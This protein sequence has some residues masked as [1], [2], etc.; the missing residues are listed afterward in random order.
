M[1]RVA[2]YCLGNKLVSLAKDRKTAETMECQGLE[3]IFPEGETLYFWPEQVKLSI[4]ETVREKLDIC[5]DYDVFQINSAGIFYRCYDS[6][7]ADNALMITAHCNS[8][9]IMCP[10]TDTQRKS[11]NTPDLREFLNIIRHIPS[12]CEHLTLTGG[13]PFLFGE[14]FFVILDRLRVSMPRTEYLLLT[15]GRAFAY[16]PYIVHFKETAPPNMLI[17]IPLHGYDAKTHDRITRS[18]GGFLQTATGIKRLLKC[19]YSVEIRIVVSKL[20]RTFIT[21]IAELIATEFQGVSR[22]EIMGLEMLGNAAV[23]KEDVWIPYREAFLA[24]KEAID[25]L[26]RLSITVGLYNFPL[27]AVDREY[28]LIAAKSITDFKV[29]YPEKCKGCAVKD[30]C[31]GVFQGS[32]RL[33]EKDIRPVLEYD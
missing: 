5:S 25:L 16:M 24:A 20:N 11:N 14:D 33:A 30:A 3:Y 21:Q 6:A 10:A 7:S 29:R 18:P 31:G 8:N 23:Y 9:C 22:V 19:G 17:G 2:E 15:N 12:D 13:E 28:Y 27:C 26:V 32:L 1:I 4:D